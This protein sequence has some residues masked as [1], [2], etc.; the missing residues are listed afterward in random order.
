MRHR[1][2]D[3]L[4]H[5]RTS[6]QH[7]ELKGTA[8]VIFRHHRRARD[9]RGHGRGIDLGAAGILRHPQENRAATQID[10]ARTFIK[11]ENRICTQARDC[12]IGEGQFAAR[13]SSGTHRRVARDLVI[14]RRRFRLRLPW[15]QFHIF[16]HRCD[17]CLFQLRAEFITERDEKKNE[18]KE[19]TQHYVVADF[20]QKVFP[21]SMGIMTKRNIR[22]LNRRDSVLLLNS[23]DH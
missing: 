7:D 20:T 6:F 13:I 11:T 1:I 17:A 4:T 2:D 8:L 10:R 16:Y 5:P 21:R 18:R 14:H 19:K 9:G 3:R 22:Q 23:G 12:Q 15:Q